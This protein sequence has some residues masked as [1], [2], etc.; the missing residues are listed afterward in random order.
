M[1]TTT[2]AAQR[3]LRDPMPADRPAS[4]RWHS[5]V[6]AAACAPMTLAPRLTS[7]PL[8]ASAVPGT[9]KPDL[10]DRVRARPA[11]PHPPTRQLH[12]ASEPTARHPSLPASACRDLTIAHPHPRCPQVLSPEL[13]PRRERNHLAL[14]SRLQ[15]FQR[16]P[17]DTGSTE[18]QGQPPRLPCA[19]NGPF[20][21][22]AAGLPPRGTAANRPGVPHR[23]PPAPCEPAECP[24]ASEHES[25]AA[26]LPACLAHCSGT[27][28]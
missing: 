1:L 3:L 23:P 6:R 17:G 4:G 20:A 19:G 15:D 28:D 25:T 7:P 11:A 16:F 21:Q 14:H 22:A 5:S 12:R 27:A 9:E 2:P 13:M 26:L 24:G 8:P 18:V 10:V